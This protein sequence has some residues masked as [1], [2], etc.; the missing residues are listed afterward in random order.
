M[1]DSWPRAGRKF[2]NGME[3][4]RVDSDVP[5]FD[6]LHDD[7]ETTPEIEKSS[8]ERF[9]MT[10]KSVLQRGHVGAVSDYKCKFS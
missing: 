4:G 6:V 5:A 2:Q 1:L 8:L 9:F 7:F 10:G 3:T